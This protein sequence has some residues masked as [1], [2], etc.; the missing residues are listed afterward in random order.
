MIYSIAST[1]SCRRASGRDRQES[2]PKCYCDLVLHEI[3]LESRQCHLM[4][5]LAHGYE[6]PSASLLVVP[7][8]D[9]I[10]NGSVP[11]RFRTVNPTFRTSLRYVFSLLLSR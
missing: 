9:T 6:R 4:V 7:H 10:A 2:H 8:R 5:S 11:P 3:L 1:H